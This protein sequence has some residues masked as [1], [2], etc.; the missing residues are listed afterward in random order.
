[1]LKLLPR[2][3][4]LVLAV[5]CVGPP[6]TDTGSPVSGSADVAQAAPAPRADSNREGVELYRAGRYPEAEQL[7]EQALAAR[8]AALGA[9]HPDVAESLGNLA[10]LYHAQGR[11]PEALAAIRR[12]ANIQTRR[13]TTDGPA[14]GGLDRVYVFPDLVDISFEVGA[15]DPAQQPALIDETFRAGQRA[16]DG[17]TAAALARVAARFAAGE[18][19]LARLARERQ[20]SAERWR[21]LDDALVRAAARPPSE[22]DAATEARLRAEL[23]AVEAQAGALDRELGERFPEYKELTDPAPLGVNDAVGLLAAD[24]ALLVY[25]V[26]PA[27]EPEDKPALA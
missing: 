10:Q 21:A 9:G 17:D 2:L 27:A 18:D 3:L 16:G 12:A 13:G 25:L 15:R 6:G 24:E 4:P 20:D 11:L 19:A 8:E 1:V 5:A 7:L 22:R 14:G 23:V 26:L